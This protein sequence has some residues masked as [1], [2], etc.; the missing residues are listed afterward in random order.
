MAKRKA[1]NVDADMHFALFD[2]L[3]PVKSPVGI[4]MVGAP[5]ASGVDNPQAGTP[6][7]TVS[8]PDHLMKFEHGIFKIPLVF[9]L[10]KIVV[11]SV[12]WREILGEHSPLAAAHKRVKDNVHD[13]DQRVFAFALF[14]VKVFSDRVP[15]FVSDV[16]WIICHNRV[17]LEILYKITKKYSF[18]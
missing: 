2:F 17:N 5:C 13:F 8:H 11:N 4:H 16:G 12:V 10:P 3:V 6:V 18:I 15:L 9:P 1:K 7:P 14:R